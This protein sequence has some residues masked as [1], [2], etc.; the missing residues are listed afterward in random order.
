MIQARV[1]VLLFVLLLAVPLPFLP[2]YGG[3]NSSTRLMLTGAIVEESST[4]I[5]RYAHLTVD[6]AE[7]GGHF[8]SDKAPGMALL[9]LPVY[10]V[11]EA[12]APEATTALF[13]FDKSLETRPPGTVVLYRLITLSTGGLMLAL[14]GVALFHMCLRLGGPPRA[15]LMASLSVCLA[16]PMLGWSVQFFGHVTAGAALACAFALATGIAR[17]GT[18]L[19]ARARVMLAAGALSLAVSTEYTAAP[20]AFAIACYAVWRMSH[21]TSGTAVRLL[22]LA[23]LAALLAALPMLIYHWVSFGSPF[24]VGYSSVVGFEGMQQG[25]LGLTAPDPVVLWRILFGFKRGMLW[26]SPLLVLVPWGLWMGLRTPG[27]RAETG[28]CALLILYYFL[29]NASYYYWN[30][31]ASVG[32]RHALPAVVFAAVPLWL[33]WRTAQGRMRQILLGLFALSVGFSLACASMTMTVYANMRF[34]LKDPILENLFT[35]QN[36]FLRHAAWGLSPALSFGVWLAIVAALTA[37]LVRALP[38]QS[39]P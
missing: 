35:G 23:L 2:E 21:L 18:V 25:F 8:Y 29:L 38:A 1:S 16:T 19:G 10:A 31:G 9:A 27:L 11:A 4:R 6:R 37:L 39:R 12:V 26:L 24:R 15:A 20:P 3:A 13:A 7:A 33:V 36:A 32:P 28:L 22:G 30:G 34:P 5:D 14:A 17:S